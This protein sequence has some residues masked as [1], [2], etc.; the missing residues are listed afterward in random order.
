MLENIRV[1]L[2]NTS[3]PG[4]IGA[5][6]R[7]MKTMGLSDLVLVEP[8]SYPHADATARASGAGDVLAAAQVVSSLQDALAGCHLVMG[9]SARSRNISLPGLDARQCGAQVVQALGQNRVALV[10]GRERTGLTNAELEHCHYLVH[11]PANPDYSSLNIAAAVQIMAY[12][13][14]IQSLG[15]VFAPESEPSHPVAAEE[16]QRFYDHLQQVLIETEFLD[17]ENPRQL[18][19]RLKRMFNRLQPDQMEMNI[20][21][22][23][24][25]SVQK[26]R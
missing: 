16:M 10:F 15:Q 25:T 4:N 6:A 24:L 22:G 26:R 21:R 12:E 23:I 13:C 11:I 8:Q 18:V 1:V 3:H 20:L 9:I 7:A 14:R 17:P 5:T 19:R 2:V